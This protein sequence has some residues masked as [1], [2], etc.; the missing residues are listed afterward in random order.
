MAPTLRSNAGNGTEALMYGSVA[1]PAAVKP[2]N[3]VMQGSEG[4]AAHWH[5]KKPLILLADLK[6]PA[7]LPLS[8]NP[9]GQ[10]DGM[11]YFAW[12]GDGQYLVVDVSSEKFDKASIKVAKVG[13]CPSSSRSW[14]PGTFKASAGRFNPRSRPKRYWP[15]LVS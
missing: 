12:T 2:L 6:T 11:P 4:R 14:L 13:S 5:P 10:E 8:V 1:A 15:P 9:G 7:T 3:G